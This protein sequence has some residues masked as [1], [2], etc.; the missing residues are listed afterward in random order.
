MSGDNNWN[1]L[2]PWTYSEKETASDRFQQEFERQSSE[3]LR[4]GVDEYERQL[5]SS[6]NTTNYGD[7]NSGDKISYTEGGCFI[8]F[9]DAIY[10]VPNEKYTKV[11]WPHAFKYLPRI[12]EQIMGKGPGNLY[13]ILTITN[14][15]HC[16]GISGYHIK[17]KLILGVPNGETPKVC[18]GYNSFPQE[19]T[20]EIWEK[21]LKV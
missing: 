21:A 11:E 5:L 3:R 20:E 4:L 10:C 14:I 13:P 7:R 12:G 15:I 6:A 18:I 1:G 9:E 16:D 17:Y 2:N 8:M 19:L